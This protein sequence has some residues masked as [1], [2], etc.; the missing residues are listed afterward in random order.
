MSPGGSA[1]SAT[2]D[3]AAALHAWLVG[4]LDPQDTTTPLTNRG[5][6]GVAGSDSSRCTQRPRN[7]ADKANPTWRHRAADSAPSPTRTDDRI[8]SCSC[9]K[10]AVAVASRVRRCHNRPLMLEQ[11][12][13]EWVAAILRRS[14]ST[15]WGVSDRQEHGSALRLCARFTLPGRTEKKRT[16]A[17][18]LRVSSRIALRSLERGSWLVRRGSPQTRVGI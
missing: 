15:A 14:S 8:V 16:G 18:T 5:S 1:G 6:S 9:S 2:G 12:W 7:S 3:H 17:S 4:K 11:S 10:S 13:I